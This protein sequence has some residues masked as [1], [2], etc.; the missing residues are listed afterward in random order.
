MEW[1][2]GN[3][4]YYMKKV[5]RFVTDKYEKIKDYMWQEESDSDYETAR[6]RSRSKSR[7]RSKMSH[8]K[9]VPIN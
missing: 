5:A 7:K 9:V 3:T 2:I 6:S 8:A 4:G 1:A